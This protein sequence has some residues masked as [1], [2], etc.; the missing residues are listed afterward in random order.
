MV[1]WILFAAASVAAVAAESR[2]APAAWSEVAPE[3]EGLDP[4]NLNKAWDYVISNKP[5]STSLLVARYGKLVFERYHAGARRHD[6]GN[7][8]SISKSVLSALVG[9][10]LAE[11]RIRNI[12]DRVDS[13]IP[14]IF[15]Q[16]RDPM[17]RTIRI[18]HLLTMTA[19]LTWEE[20]GAVTQ[21][22]VSSFNPNRFALSQPFVSLPGQRF[23][24]STALT[25]LLSAVLTCVTGTSMR[26]YAASR[27]FGPL[28]ITNVRWDELAG[29][30][31]GGAELYLTA[32]DLARFGQLLLQKGRWDDRQ[33]VP[34]EWVAE[35]TSPQGREFY[36]YLWWLHSVGGHRM[37][38]AQGAFGQ[39]VC[40]VPEY[41]LVIAHT[42]GPVSGRRASALPLD[43]I[44][45]F[46]F[47][48]VR[49]LQK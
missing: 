25:H 18:R 15:A 46:I 24:Y 13:Y 40:I 39:Y 32:R 31:F 30:T 38:C 21:A 33:L 28:G 42:S 48:A 6:A 20:N 43:M 16:V 36:G 14:E 44:P 23:E 41:E 4:R 47:P 45:R 17:A 7:V 35:S 37:V 1:R 26:R 34:E 27:I 29:I 11:G 2:A 12:D 19:G 5:A 22:W 10:A 9:I 8:K 49:Q 3:S